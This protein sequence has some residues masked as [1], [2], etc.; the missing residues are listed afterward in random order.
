MPIQKKEPAKKRDRAAS[1]RALIKAAT[2]LFAAKGFDGTRTLEISKKA[3]VNEALITRYFGGKEGLLVAVLE[4]NES[5]KIE[6]KNASIG[7]DVKSIATDACWIPDYDSGKDLKKTL[8]DFFKAGFNH[9]QD[10]ESLIRITLSQALVDPKIAFVLRQKT[11]E[12]SMPVMQGV[13]KKHIGKKLSPTELE[14]LAMLL[15]ATN[16]AFNF[17]GRVVHG[18][19]GKRVDRSIQLLVD[20]L[21]AKLD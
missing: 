21:V 4:E 15:M 3:K 16:F 12:K 9:F 10:Q 8:N 17:M 7:V 18:V 6:N 11:L 14:S 1:E 2:V 19:D 20:A 13:M 5:K